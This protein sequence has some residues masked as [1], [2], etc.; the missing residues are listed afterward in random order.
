MTTTS[1]VTTGPAVSGGNFTIAAVEA[2]VAL[3][4]GQY[5]TVYTVPDGA[6]NATVN[7]RIITNNLD[8]TALVTPFIVGSGYSTGTQPTNTDLVQPPNLPLGSEGVQAGIVE[9]TGVVML[10][11]TSL[12][13]WS[14]SAVTVRM[15]G[16]LKTATGG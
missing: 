14:D 10:P 5:V 12:V 13:V 3:P 2:K 11:G 6:A 16:Y 9:D 15:H 1:T 8:E 7:Y 4:G